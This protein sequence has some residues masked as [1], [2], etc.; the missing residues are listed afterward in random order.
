M[1]IASTMADYTF[2]WNNQVPHVMKSFNALRKN[3][4]L[5][6]V[7]LSCERKNIPAHKV[8]LSACSPYFK[9]LFEAR[10]QLPVFSAAHQFIFFKYSQEI[11]CPHPVIILRN[12]FFDDL[13]AIMEYMYTGMVTVRH[14][15]LASFVDTGKLLDIDGLKDSNHASVTSNN[16]HEVKKK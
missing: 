4:E 6:D 1:F 15:Q 3:K 13:S 16:M 12:V 9:N 14:S 11:L 7:T 2:T 8:M 10:N 5:I